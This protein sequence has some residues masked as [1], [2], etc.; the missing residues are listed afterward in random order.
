MKISYFNLISVERTKILN[1]FNE[2]ELQG[3]MYFN[4]V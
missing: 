3:Q 2:L 1:Q 4:K